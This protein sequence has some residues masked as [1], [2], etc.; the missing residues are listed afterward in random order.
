MSEES[1]ANETSQLE[2]LVIRIYKDKMENLYIKTGSD[3]GF[4]VRLSDGTRHDGT[5]VGKFTLFKEIEV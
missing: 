3:T 1:K 2:R 5:T 4:M